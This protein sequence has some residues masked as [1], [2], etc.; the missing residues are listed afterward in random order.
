M[1]WR[2]ALAIVSAIALFTIGLGVIVYV[3]VARDRLTPSAPNIPTPGPTWTAMPSE[4]PTPAAISV[5]GV[6]SDYTPGALIIVLA[7]IEGNVEQIIVLEGVRVEREGGQPAAPED[8]APGQTLFAEGALDPLGRL[9]AERIV[10]V[11]EGETSPEASASPSPSATASATPSITPEASV[12]PTRTPMAAWEGEYF[13]NPDL[14]GAPVASRDDAA[15]DFDWGSGAP[16]D[17]VPQDR[18]SVRWTTRRSLEAGTHRFYARADDGVR[19]YVNN[20]LVIDAWHG[21]IDTVHQGDVTL[22]AGVHT[23]RVEYREDSGE[24]LVQVW[25]D[26]EGYYPE[27][28]G[29][30]YANPTLSGSPALVRNDPEIRFDWGA[31]SPAPDLPADQFSVRWT[32]M[33]RTDAGPYR[34]IADADDGVRIWVDDALILDTWTT[35]A[36]GKQMGHIWLEAGQHQVRIEY[37]EASGQAGIHIWWQ[38]LE[39]YVGWQGAYYRNPDLA[40]QPVLVRDDLIIDFDWGLG[41]PDPN[42]P[43]DN[44]SVRWRRIIPFERG[45]YR[46]WAQADDGIRVRVDGRLIIDQW[47]DAGQALYQVEID[48]EAGEHE[49][50]VEYYERGEQAIARFGYDLASTPTATAT[51]TATPT[52]TPAPSATPTATWT[53]APPTQTATPSPTLTPTAT[54]TPEPTEPGPPAP[55]PTFPLPPEL[56]TRPPSRR[57]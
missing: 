40:G 19:V 50:V 35:G 27:W 28:R 3:A 31:A 13:S 32:R 24:A 26:R 8:I 39:D 22:E 20:A 25:W 37:Y 43:V 55:T 23:L 11:A 17:G 51:W 5:A 15:I 47:R 49:V 7:P 18:F 44:F 9:I 42:I 6:V 41:A 12:T 29:E 21:P 16:L 53:P 56:P 46:F 33:L 54:P 52:G 34:V 1:M 2:K 36:R 57:D 38:L 4:A 45:R 10:I 48:L 14:R 30:Y